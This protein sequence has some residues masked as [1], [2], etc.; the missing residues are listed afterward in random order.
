MD[1]LFLSH[2]VP[3]PP[4]KGEKIRANQEVLRLCRSHRVHL[5]CFAR[6]P[7]DLAAARAMERHCASVFASPLSSRL[8]LARAAARF[9]LGGS[10]SAA[11]YGSDALRRRVADLRAS[12]DL[13]A[14]VAYSGVMAPYAPADIPLILDMVDVDSEKW[15]QYSRERVPGFA[16]ALEGRRLRRIEAAAAARARRAIL[17]T[18]AEAA[19]LRSFAPAASVAAMENGVDFDFFDPSAAPPIP[20]LEGRRALV[21]VGVMDYYPNA[22]GA[23]RFAERVFPQLRAADPALEFWIVGRNPSKAV[24][25]L[26]SSPGIVVTGGVPDVRPYLRSAV[27]AVAPLEIARGIQNKVLEALAMGK[28]VLASPAVCKTFGPHLPEGVTPAA[29]AADYAS[30]LASLPA[31]ASRA[32]AIRESARARFSWES[33][34]AILDS[35]L[36]AAVY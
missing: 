24:A 21:F 17:A 8:A 23:V 26:A 9:A 12:V 28:P 1:I 27:A 14:A 35:A 10:L 16:Y 3:N 11:F 32:A 30:A 19:L 7:A 4:D 33:N 29:S 36:A 6:G 34:L 2:C 5:V 20:A 22:A 31:G 18:E 15:L 13:R 25:R